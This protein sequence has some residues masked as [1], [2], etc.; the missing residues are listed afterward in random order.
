MKRPSFA[1]RADIYPCASCGEVF[2]KVHLL[3]LHQAARHALS[4][5]FDGDSG[6]NIVKIIFRSGWKGGGGGMGV[7]AAGGSGPAIHRVLKIH[8]SPRTLGRFEEYRDAVRSRAAAGG[9]D[10]RCVVDGNERLRFYCATFLCGLAREGNPGTCDSPFCAACSIVRHGF[11]GK[12]ADGI[13]THAT[14]WAAHAALPE[15]LEREFAFMHVRRAMLVCRVVAGRVAPGQT[16]PPAGTAEAEGVEYEYDSVVA[17][18]GG[19]EGG[20]GPWTVEG[21]LVVFN[22]RAVLPCFV[23]VYN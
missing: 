17:T 21:K 19:R 6:K 4:E 5:L 11:S 23:V 20:G 10:E 14:A 1:S 13:P 18:A 22:A 7:D 12:D 16:G 2:N 15:E 9:A 3:D 8:H